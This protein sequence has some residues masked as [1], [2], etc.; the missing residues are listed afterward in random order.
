[1]QN[2]PNDTKGEQS[3][4]AENITW[5]RVFDGETLQHL[6]DLGT[7]N[8]DYVYDPRIGGSGNVIWQPLNP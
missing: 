6:C 4:S 1:M 2:K 7:T 5:F 8:P 3:N